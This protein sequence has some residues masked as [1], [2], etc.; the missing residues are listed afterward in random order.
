MAIATSAFVPRPR[1]YGFRNPGLVYGDVEDL[2]D[3]VNSE[4]QIPYIATCGI[5]SN[6]VVSRGNSWPVPQEVE[7]SE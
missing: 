5:R 7:V 3:L 1:R 2:G 6:P 4:E